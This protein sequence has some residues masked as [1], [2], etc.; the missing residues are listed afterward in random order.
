MDLAPYHHAK[1][2]RD[3]NKPSEVDSMNRLRVQAE[4]KAAM[5]HDEVLALQV[6]KVRL[7]AALCMVLDIAQRRL[8][9]PAEVTHVQALLVESDRPGYSDEEVA[10]LNADE[11]QFR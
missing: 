2:R 11:R 4:N 1:S 8:L 10:A 6:Q 3:M 5:L 7:T 9:L